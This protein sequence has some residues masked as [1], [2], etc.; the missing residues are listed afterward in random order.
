[1]ILTYLHYSEPVAAGAEYSWAAYELLKQI[2]NE[3]FPL[4]CNTTDLGNHL[5]DT[6]GCIGCW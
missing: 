3:K 4:N 6:G 1:M 2:E 5:P